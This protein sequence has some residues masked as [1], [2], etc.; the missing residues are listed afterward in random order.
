MSWSDTDDTTDNFTDETDT[1]VD[2]FSDTSDA[3]DSFNDILHTDK[4]YL[5][6][7]NGYYLLQEN[8]AKILIQPDPDSDWSN[9]SNASGSWSDA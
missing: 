4:G 1:T 3:P 5:L 6:Q 8:G 9:E 2:G 7:E